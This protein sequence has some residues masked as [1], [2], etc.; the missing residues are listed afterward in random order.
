MLQDVLY[1]RNILEDETGHIE[2]RLN[3]ILAVV[4]LRTI[5]HVL[6]NVDGEG[7][8]QV[9][10][11]ARAMHARWKSGHPADAIFRDFIERERNSILKEYAFSMSEGPVPIVAHLQAQDGYDSIRHFLIEENIYRPIEDGPYQGEDGRTV[12]DD[13]IEWWNRQLDE[14]D[15]VL[16]GDE[17]EFL[18]KAMW[19]PHLV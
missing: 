8:P 5:G 7:S 14:I 6:N 15:R 11:L 17:D 10:R 12:L 3:W 1:V 9:R 4:L 13:A 19:R 16:I 18:D 2:W